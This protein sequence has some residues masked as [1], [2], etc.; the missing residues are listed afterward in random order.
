MSSHFVSDLKNKILAQGVQPVSSPLVDPLSPSFFVVEPSLLPPAGAVRLC[1]SLACGGAC[2][3]A[4]TFRLSTTALPLQPEK[5]ANRTYAPR[6][7]QLYCHAQGFNVK[8]THTLTRPSLATTRG[9]KEAPLFEG[10]SGLKPAR[11]TYPTRCKPDMTCLAA[12]PAEAA[13]K[14]Q[15]ICCWH[16]V[17][18]AQA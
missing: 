10:E 15:A 8:N 1:R 3:R 7:T 5:N 2:L 6:T 18:E 17:L 4:R 12:C 13:R 16:L 14:T 9:S 11:K